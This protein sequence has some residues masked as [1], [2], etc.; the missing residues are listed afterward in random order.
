MSR[1]VADIV[2]PPREQAAAQARGFAARDEGPCAQRRAL[3]C[4]RRAHS[5]ARRLLA[6]TRSALQ[7]IN[8]ARPRALR[9]A[10]TS[11]ARRPRS[12]YARRGTRR[13]DPV[14]VLTRRA[15]QSI[16]IGDEIVVTVLDVRGDQVRIGIKAPRSVDVHRE[17]VFVA[18]QQA[19]RDAA[20]R[21]S[22]RDAR[23]RGAAS[24][25]SSTTLR[26]R[27]PPSNSVEV[28]GTRVRALR[29]RPR[30]VPRRRAC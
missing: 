12:S 1:V 18:L 16:M 27:R 3:R 9:R 7:T 28:R 4:R 13:E 30:S 23:R 2:A 24:S 15:N 21:R 10:R 22:D 17:E 20:Q 6:L 11:R 14:L 8:D 25:I 26:S 29:R 19:N 5:I